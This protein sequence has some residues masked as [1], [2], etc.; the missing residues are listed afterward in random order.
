VTELTDPTRVPGDT[1]R[2]LDKIREAEQA[3]TKG[4]WSATHPDQCCRGACIVNQDDQGVHDLDPISYADQKFIALARTAVPLLEE[5]L[6]AVL[7]EC[8]RG[9]RARLDQPMRYVRTRK[10]RRVIAESLSRIGE[11]E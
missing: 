10:I 6:R 4:P 8:D 1:L 2:V 11:T 7:D 3:A 9:D 5:A